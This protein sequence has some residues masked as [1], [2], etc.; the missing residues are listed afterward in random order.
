MQIVSTTIPLRKTLTALAAVLSVVGLPCNA[1][2]VDESARLSE[3]N[4]RAEQTTQKRVEKLSDATREM[5][6]EYNALAREL[7]ALRIYNEQVE[8]LVASQE[9][10]KLS[11]AKQM[12][13]IDFTHREVVPLMLRMIDGL[14]SFVAADVPFLVGERRERVARLREVMDRAD[15][16][17]AEKYR[18]ILEAYRIEMDYGRTIEAYRDE[19]EADAESGAARRTV[20]FVRVGRVGLY[21][22]SLDGKQGGYWDALAGQWEALDGTDRLAVREALRIARKQTAPALLR[23]PVPA[24]GQSRP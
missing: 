6:D 21:F 4:N 23:L 2:T 9:E 24:P 5:L 15:V 20:D 22:L 13:D 18:R 19:I 16:S 17:V 3:K 12:E 1:D 10:E 11:L 8:R 14:D 7:D